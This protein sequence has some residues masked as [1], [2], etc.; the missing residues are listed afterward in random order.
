MDSAVITIPHT[1]YDNSGGYILIDALRFSILNKQY[2]N[3]YDI[4]EVIPFQKLTKDTIDRLFKL[5]I[6]FCA[7]KKDIEAVLDMM[8]SNIEILERKKYTSNKYVEALSS[9]YIPMSEIINIWSPAVVTDSNGLYIDHPF[10]EMLISLLDCDDNEYEIEYILPKIEIIRKAYYPNYDFSVIYK[11]LIKNRSRF[12]LESAS[13]Y[14]FRYIIKKYRLISIPCTKPGWIHIGFRMEKEK[15]YGPNNPTDDEES[16][17][18]LEGD[19]W[20]NGY[21]E[22]CNRTILRKEYAVRAPGFGGAWTGC[23]CSW[24]HTFGLIDNVDNILFKAFIEYFK[25]K[26]YEDGVWIEL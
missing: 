10:T 25:T 21:C 14:T 19:K 3:L 6:D 13:E 24:K 18:M 5:L 20:F 11:Y 8:L 12:N 4:A 1:I 15:I 23:Y 7:D 9:R 26:I 22:E 2:D 17:Y 16:H